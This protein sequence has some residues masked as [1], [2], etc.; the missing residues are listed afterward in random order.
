MFYFEPLKH[1]INIWDYGS[2]AIARSWLGLISVNRWTAVWSGSWSGTAHQTRPS[3]PFPIYVFK[4]RCL[5][6]TLTDKFTQ[7]KSQSVGQ[8]SVG[9]TPNRNILHAKSHRLK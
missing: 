7:T 8:A 2:P 5:E 3:K 4:E 1:Q 9:N 6:V